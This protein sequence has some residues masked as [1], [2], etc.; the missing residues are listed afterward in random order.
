MNNN[1]EQKK[2]Y[3][4][5]DTS[6]ELGMSFRRYWNECNK[7]A[8]AAETYATKVGAKAY[9]QDASLM[10]GG[11]LF[12]TFEDD[13]TVDQRIWKSVGK[14]T[15]GEE[16]WVPRCEHR[17]GVMMLPRRNF[18]PSNTAYRVYSK[19]LLG[20][21][22]VASEHSLQEWA[23]IAG[24]GLTGDKE[25]D[26]ICVEEVMKNGAFLRYTDLYTTDIDTGTEYP[27]TH[28]RGNGK[29]ER[30]P[31][32]AKRAIH[33]ELQRLTLP[34]V[35]ILSLYRMLQ[36]DMTNGDNSSRVVRLPGWTPSS[37]MLYHNFYISTGLPCHHQDLQE[38]TSVKFN[39]KL[40]EYENEEK[41]KALLN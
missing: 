5:F 36:A 9:H 17:Q 22:Q 4:R 15:N 41:R 28:E 21:K 24:I 16:G 10:E 40:M 12:V 32:W 30:M 18:R 11:V 7:A 27:L 37:F 29:R 26:N 39:S 6:S 31:L 2:Y 33:L 35:S 20:W 25:K 34:T 13:K 38:L 19:Q 8:R 3:Y 14:A 1:K 23:D